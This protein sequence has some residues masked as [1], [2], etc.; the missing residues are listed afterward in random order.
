MSSSE[1]QELLCQLAYQIWLD[2]VRPIGS[3][4]P[5]LERI[6]AQ[7]RAV[8]AASRQPAPPLSPRTAPRTAAPRD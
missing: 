8:R 4:E 1:E 3:P 2:R 5:D 6:A 7:I